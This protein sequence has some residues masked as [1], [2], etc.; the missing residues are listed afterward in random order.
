MQ[1]V[2]PC[3][4]AETTQSYPH[5]KFIEAKRPCCISMKLL[6]LESGLPETLDQVGEDGHITL[7]QP[8]S[9]LFS[10]LPPSYEVRGKVM[11]LSVQGGTLLTGPGLW[12]QVLSLGEGREGLPQC[13]VQVLSQG[14]VGTQGVP[15]HGPGQGVGEEVS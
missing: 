5:C 3:A 9:V 14:E 10:L 11:S 6:M 13:L 2:Y 15:Y 8:N 7:V 1:L 12:S 4:R